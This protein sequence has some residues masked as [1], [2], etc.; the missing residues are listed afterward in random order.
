MLSF[1]KIL[2]FLSLHE[3]KR[4][5]LLLIMILIMALIDMVGVAS[6]LPFMSVLTNPSLVESNIYL[7]NFFQFMSIFGV[8]NNQQ[9]L[10]ALGLV[11]FL[12]L[13]SSLAFKALTTY[14]QVR[15][16]QMREYSISKKLIEGYLHQPYSWFLNRNS[17]DLGKT[18]L[19]E[20]AQLINYGMSPLIELIARALLAI[21]LIFL[22]VMVDLNL[23]IIIGLSLGGSYGLIIIFVRGYLNKIGKERLKNN[24]L[25]FASVIEAF[26]AAKEI[27]V[28]GLEKFYIKNF[29]TSAQIFAKTQA[30]S[31]VISQLPRYILEAIGFG[32]ILIIMLYSL[33]KTGSFNSSLPILSLYVFAGYR[34]LPT[35]QLI[36]VS[37]TKLA[38]VRPS[39]D[40]LYDDMKNLSPIAFNN[41][42]DVLTLKKEINLNNIQYSY[43]NSSKNVLKNI[44]LNI[45]AKCTVGI[46]G[47]TGSGKTTMVDII[48]GLLEV[49]KGTLEVDG[50]II[51]KKNLRAWQSSIGY[52]PQNIFLAD[53]TLASNIAFGAEDKDIDF[54]T[55]KKVSKISHLHNFVID[56][57][58]EGYQTEIGERGIRLSGGQRQ[59]IGIARA[60]Y[61]NPKV[62]ILDE[63]TSALDNQT[64]KAVI[65][66]I[67]KASKNITT[68]MIAHRLGTLKN[69]DLVVQLED[70]IIK[71]I[72][73]PKNLID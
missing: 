5:C 21:A 70:G 3:R 61:H 24:E 62:L 18:I 52:V 30:S 35:L 66:S 29:S 67:N 12:L 17:A 20:V 26:G 54:K 50:K 56:E 25:R 47:T 73:S 68:I 10:F 34:L 36:Y 1:K 72:G 28:A 41:F 42:E 46:M 22:L 16:V 57:L 49:Q 45:P 7:N 14:A 39:L 11:V 2:F 40:K 71:N 6:I 59:R 31:Q 65:D 4:A 27:K 64:E 43:P 8:K 38:F 19:S 32:G 58:S 60:L 37:L 44:S 15:F 55:I 13:I 23:A 9:F 53:D 48:L 33:S 51:T 69:C 63:A